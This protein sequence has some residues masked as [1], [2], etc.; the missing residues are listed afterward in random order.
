MV[1]LIVLLLQGTVSTRKER[2]RSFLLLSNDTTVSALPTV[3]AVGRG[4]TSG[5]SGVCE[6]FLVRFIQVIVW[7]PLEDTI[8]SVGSV[9]GAHG[10]I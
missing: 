10:R 9:I 2:R 6:N 8:S 5:I 3:E 4:V 1:E 7:F